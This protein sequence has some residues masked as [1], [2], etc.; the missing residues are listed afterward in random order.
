MSRKRAP[1]TVTFLD[2]AR[3]TLCISVDAIEKSAVAAAW[4]SDQL[5]GLYSAPCLI[6]RNI[7]VAWSALESE[8]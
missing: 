1:G 5:Q 8:R 2:G 3:F 6:G 4:F 7:F